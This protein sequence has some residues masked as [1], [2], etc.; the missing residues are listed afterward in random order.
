MEWRPCPGFEDLYAISET[1]GVRRTNGDGRS[2]GLLKG[3]VGVG[4]YVRVTL[5]R[6]GACRKFLVH[7]LVCEAWHGP[8][9]SPQHEAAHE[10]GD[11][12]NNHYGNL[13]WKT[14]R[15]NCADRSKHGKWSPPKGEASPS[16]KI[17][18]AD[19]S[20]IRRRREFGLTQYDLSAK[21]GISQS[22]VSRIERGTRWKTD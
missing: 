20:F 7:R 4:G 9:P 11:N 6:N 5:S 15:E 8:P 17:T 1:G 19:V 12:A 16:A 13:A 2:K 3:E 21:L 22:Q 14:P 18:T 10:D